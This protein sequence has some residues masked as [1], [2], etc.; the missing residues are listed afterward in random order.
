MRK[1]KSTTLI[2]ALAAMMV[3]A[4][5]AFAVACGGDEGTTETTA[6]GTETTG[7]Q[8][9][10]EPIKIGAPLPLTGAYAADGQHMEMG[11]EMAVADLNA[12]GG[13]LGRPVELVTF[14]IE[15]LLPETVAASKDY[16]IEKEGIDF[17]VEGYGGYGPDFEAYGAQSDIP[18]IHGSG[19]VRAAEMVRT[20][21]ET[22]RQHVPGVLRRGRVRQARLGGHDPVRGQIRLSKQ[23][24]RASCTATWSGISTTLQPWPRR[25][26]RR[27]GKW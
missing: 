4:L 26:R 20:D 15:E 23:E 3:L 8:P 1:G 10:G 24:D 18:F 25:L 13:L 21:P 22:V 9:T 12:A 14:D 6:A 19:S 7:A 2:M 27:V 16:L 5:A 17:V 11:L